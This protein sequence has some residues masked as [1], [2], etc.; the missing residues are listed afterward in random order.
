MKNKA[1]RLKNKKDYKESNIDIKKNLK[2]IGKFIIIMLIIIAIFFIVENIAGDKSEKHI[3]NIE[4]ERTFENLTIK[5][6]QIKYEEENSY[7]KLE[8]LNESDTDFAERDI[9]I[10]FKNEDN[11]EFAN[12]RYHLNN[13]KQKD[14][15]YINTSINKDLTQAKDFYIENE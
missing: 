14:T 3:K 2:V 5:N 6:I 15:F 12:I 13:I 8:L 4:K 9:K 10:I 1:R 11:T 7:F